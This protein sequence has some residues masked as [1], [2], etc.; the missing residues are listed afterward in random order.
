[1][2][3]RNIGLYLPTLCEYMTLHPDSENCCLEQVHHTH[4][5]V[6]SSVL[7]EYTLYKLRFLDQTTDA[8]TL[9]VG[10]GG[11]MQEYTIP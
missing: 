7:V 11:E 2:G 1:M 4:T 10:G 8:K 9:S 6:V 5:V 3:G